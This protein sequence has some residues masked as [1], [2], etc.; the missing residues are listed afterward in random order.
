MVSNVVKPFTFRPLPNVW[1]QTFVNIWNCLLGGDG[2]GVKSGNIHTCG[3]QSDDSDDSWVDINP[4]E[5][6]NSLQ[7][8]NSRLESQVIRLCTE[9]AATENPHD[10]S[11]HN[12]SKW[13]SIFYQNPDKFIFMLF[14]L[15]WT[16]S[17][18]H[19]ESDEKP[20]RK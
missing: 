6:Q 18:R 2:E 1:R 7:K 11:V 15:F 17:W 9:L 12:V 3:N 13:Q 16:W 20:P 19:L 5:I 10:E 14:L 4:E 8:E